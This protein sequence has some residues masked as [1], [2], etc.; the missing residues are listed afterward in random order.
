MMNHEFKTWPEFFAALL[1]GEKTFELR[2][3]DR[4]FVIGD[5]LH[6]REYDLETRTYSGRVVRRKVIYLLGHR[7]TAGCAA[8]FGLQP[9][10]VIMG[11][12]PSPADRLPGGG[13]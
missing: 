3:D 9:G 1:A 12:S 11:L 2:K 8:T 5:I 10:Y 13:Q 4:G 7:A 6:L